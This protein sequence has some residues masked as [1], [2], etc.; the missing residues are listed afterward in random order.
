MVEAGRQDSDEN[1]YSRCRMDLNAAQIV[2]QVILARRLLAADAALLPADQ[3]PNLTNVV[4]RS[5]VGVLSVA[6]PVHSH[7]NGVSV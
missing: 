7:V 1:E 2:E 4:S 6:L 5:S 3:A